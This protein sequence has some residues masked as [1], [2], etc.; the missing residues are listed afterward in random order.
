MHST[1]RFETLR[2]K[3]LDKLRARNKT[4]MGSNG[5]IRKRSQNGNGSPKHLPNYN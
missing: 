1:Y 4:L 3:C 2:R 5:W